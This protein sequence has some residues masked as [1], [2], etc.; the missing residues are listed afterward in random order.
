[1]PQNQWAMHKGTQM[2]QGQPDKDKEEEKEMSD[3]KEKDATAMKKA[4]WKDKDG[5]NGT[6]WMGFQG[7]QRCAVSCCED[8][9]HHK[10]KAASH[11]DFNKATSTT[12]DDAGSTFNSAS[13]GELLAGVGET[14]KAI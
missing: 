10:Q 11:D 12:L 4:E 13:N 6:G 1:M 3:Q 8:Q 2:S 5:N 9:G 7:L 14:N